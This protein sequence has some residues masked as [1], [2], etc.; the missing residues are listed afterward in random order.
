MPQK[1]MAGQ[2][3]LQGEPAS[4]QGIA[5]CLRTAVR[6]QSGE[7]QARGWWDSLASSGDSGWLEAPL[8]FARGDMHDVKVGQ[9]LAVILWSQRDRWRHFDGAAVCGT[10]VAVVAKCWPGLLEQR[11]SSRP[12]RQPA[13]LRLHRRPVHP[14]TVGALLPAMASTYL[15]K[16]CRACAA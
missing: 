1:K 7:L 8:Y 16:L 10:S 4:M 13:S 2:A 12:T 5:T 9:P 6:A 11:C 15:T 14:C 3:R